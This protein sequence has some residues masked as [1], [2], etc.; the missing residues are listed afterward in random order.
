ML[1]C[2]YNMHGHLKKTQNF[3]L[4]FFFF[5]SLPSVLFTIVFYVWLMV[6]NTTFN[7]ITVISWRRTQRKPLTCRRSLT[8]FIT[9][10][11]IV[12]WTNNI[13]P[14]SSVLFTIFFFITFI[15]LIKQN[16]NYSMPI[17]PPGLPLLWNQR[18]KWLLFQVL[19]KEKWE[20]TGRCQNI[21][22]I[23]P[24]FTFAGHYR[25]IRML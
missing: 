9:I 17:Y 6:F 15:N 23:V 1:F 24:L 7:N 19:T 18:E 12:I 25:G 16:N 10:A 14:L 20:T 8:N 2:S 21:S 4:I 22:L 3:K 13:A 11:L 5:I